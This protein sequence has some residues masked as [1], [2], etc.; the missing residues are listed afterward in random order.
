MIILKLNE[1]RIETETHYSKKYYERFKKSIE[2]YENDTKQE[3]R[4]K[5]LHC[6]T[7]Y[8]L[9]GNIAG[10]AFTA[11]TC[12]NCGKEQHHPNTN[13]PK[14]CSECAKEHQCCVRCASE[15]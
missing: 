3:Q 14:Y 6:K 12:K 1:E 2:N 15:L 13:V 8:Y 7:C 10:Q 9:K 4:L 11:Y 5:L